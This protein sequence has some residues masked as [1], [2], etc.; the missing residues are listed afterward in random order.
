MNL[1][2]VMGELAAAAGTI[3]SLRK[4]F[5]WPVTSAAPPF[6]LV[7]LPESIDYDATFR[8]GADRMSLRL[9]IAVGQPDAR[10]A[11]ERLAEYADGAGTESVKTVLEATTYTALDTVRVSRAE[12]GTITVAATE[13]LACK[14]TLDVVG[15]GG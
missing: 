5:D 11:W 15:S 7:E 8:R 10:A 14:F 4:C 12:F 13:Y 3:E 1:F 2:A 6:G 9:T